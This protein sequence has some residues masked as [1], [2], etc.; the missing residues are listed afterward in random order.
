LAQKEGRQPLSKGRMFRKGTRRGQ[1]AYTQLA[2]EPLNSSKDSI[3]LMIPLG[4]VLIHTTIRHPGTNRRQRTSPKGRTRHKATSTSAEGAATTKRYA[5]THPE[6]R[7]MSGTTWSPSPSRQA[8]AQRV[9]DV[10]YLHLSM[11]HSSS[12]SP[13]QMSNAPKSTK[14][15][16]KRCIPR[17]IH[18]L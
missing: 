11:T 17:A 18:Q 16:Y 15:E 9:P 7:D 10:T 6:N 3:Q 12:T 4:R 14:Q 1:E 8:R 13:T 2:N 5:I